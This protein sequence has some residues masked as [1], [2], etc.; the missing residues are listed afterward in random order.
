MP[1]TVSAAVAL[2]V[3]AVTGIG[4]AAA[5]VAPGPDLDGIAAIIASVTGLVAAVGTLVLGFLSRR[6]KKDDSLS[7]MLEEELKKTL[8]EELRKRK[9]AS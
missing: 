8:L 6:A 9:D 3:V 1:V 7:D 4:A 2:K 5:E